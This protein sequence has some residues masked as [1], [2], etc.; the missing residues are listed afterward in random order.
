MADNLVERM[1]TGN[2]GDNAANG[3]VTPDLGEESGKCLPISIQSLYKIFGST[4][5]QMLPLVQEG[6]DKETLRTEHE[7]ILG[8]DNVN[9]EIPEGKI[10]VV[11]GLSGSGK[12]TLIRHIN[13][14]ID[15]TSGSIRIGE[16]DVMSLTDKELLAFRRN[17][18]AMVF[19][20]FALFPHLSV[21][22]NVE[23]ALMV[24]GFSR[25]QREQA[26]EFWLAR[27]GLEGYGESYP[28]QLSGGM[29]QRVGLARALANDTPIMLMDEAFSALD[30][31]IRN[32][33]QGMLLD[34][35][36]DTNKTIVFISHDLDESLRLGDKIAILRDGRVEQQGS[37]QDIVLK[38]A[39]DHIAE[40][41]RVVNRGKVIQCKSLMHP[42]TQKLPLEVNPTMVLEEAIKLLNEHKA[43]SASVVNKSGR[44]LGEVRLNDL[45]EVIVQS[46]TGGE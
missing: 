32:D 9:L 23:Y 15:P 42:A 39:N 16:T 40:F 27:V 7:H 4:P 5:E 14:L 30:P 46:A 6:I 1:E 20:K 43:Q 19:Q 31:L 37:A 3:L 25:S 8:L 33:M 11:M 18:T 12:S 38:P 34:I 28:N 2:V 22:E 10:T 17:Q 45:L 44:L 24:R 21:A 26:T 29:Q 41:V 36:Q 13:R 35:Q